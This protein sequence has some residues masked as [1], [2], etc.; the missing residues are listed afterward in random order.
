MP[1][2]TKLFIVIIPPCVSFSENRFFILASLSSSLFPQPLP[3]HFRKHASGL[4]FSLF[5]II[6]PLESLQFGI[7]SSYVF[8]FYLF[9]D[10]YKNIC[11]HGTEVFYIKLK[12][13]CPKKKKKFDIVPIQVKEIKV[14]SKPRKERTDYS[15]NNRKKLSEEKK[16][17]SHN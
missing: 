9:Y 13:H 3:E 10:T 15:V 6:V 11:A 17:G 8:Y 16:D 5:V 1:F 4:H 2:E 12:W 7:K 14:W